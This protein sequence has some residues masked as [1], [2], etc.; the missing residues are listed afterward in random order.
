VNA[1]APNFFPSEMT[2]VL[3]EESGMADCMR[4]RTPMRRLGE[5]DELV[6]PFLFRVLLRAHAVEGDLRGA[7]RHRSKAP[8]EAMTKKDMIVSGG[9]NIYCAEVEAVIDAHPK[10]REVALIGLPHERWVETPRAIIAPVDPAD[11][12]SEAE[13]VEWCRGRPASYKKPTSVVIVEAL[14][15]NAAARC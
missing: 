4:S 7:G 8:P 14:P 13:I 5:L 1:L 9:E 11:P 15:R 10:V 2:R 6:G 12:P 3:L